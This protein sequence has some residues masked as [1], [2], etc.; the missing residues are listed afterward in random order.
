MLDCTTLVKQEPRRERALSS[1][2]GSTP[3]LLGDVNKMS[4]SRLSWHGLYTGKGDCCLTLG[5]RKGDCEEIV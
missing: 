3:F 2:I 4:A 5:K 1:A